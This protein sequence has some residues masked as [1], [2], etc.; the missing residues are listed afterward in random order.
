[1]LPMASRASCRRVLYLQCIHNMRNR[2]TRMFLA[3]TLMFSSSNDRLRTIMA[4][5]KAN[6]HSTLTLHVEFIMPIGN[7]ET[8]LCF[9][10][11][12]NFWVTM[13]K[14]IHHSVLAAAWIIL[15]MG[16]ANERRHYM[17]TPPLIG[18]AHTQND[19]W[20]VTPCHHPSH[21]FG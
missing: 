7:A 17:V 20:G 4:S 6:T 10:L 3:N 21:C 1:M 8:Y 15:G 9:L 18:R 11:S 13:V 19:P 2:N 5:C 12:L 14:L 16:S